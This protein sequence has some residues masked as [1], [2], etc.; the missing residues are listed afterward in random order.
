MGDGLSVFVMCKLYVWVC[1]YVTVCHIKAV[2]IG[3]ASPW[4]KTVLFLVVWGPIY[5]HHIVVW[6][7]REME[8]EKH[9][10]NKHV[11]KTFENNFF[12]LLT[13]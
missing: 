2:I 11:L 10:K 4:G 1:Y 9:R 8:R 7:G 3:G 5:G 6:W 12:F 13:F